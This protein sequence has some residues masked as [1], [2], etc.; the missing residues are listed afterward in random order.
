MCMYLCFG[1]LCTHTRTTSSSVLLSCGDMPAVCR[2]AAPFPLFTPHPAQFSRHNATPAFPTP[3][4]S[5]LSIS[6]FV[7]LS[8]IS[9]IL[10]PPSGNFPLCRPARASQEFVG[11]ILALLLLAVEVVDFFNWS[12]ECYH[13]R[14]TMSSS[15]E[16][17]HPLYPIPGQQNSN[18]HAS[19]AR[20]RSFR[21]LL[22]LQSAHMGG[23]GCSR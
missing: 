17:E 22:A 10:L 6:V 5:S 4:S 15:S 3:H 1:T 8:L 14:L 19:A 2:I 12:R 23:G 20:Q 16:Q 9:L 13:R 7:L 11:V 18:S 21:L